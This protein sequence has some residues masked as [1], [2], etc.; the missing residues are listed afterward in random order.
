VKRLDTAEVRKPLIS[1]IISMMVSPAK[2]LK[3]SVAKVP[4]YFSIAVSASAF[5]LFFFQTGFDLYRTGQKG[6]G[7]AL[8]SAG[9]GVVYGLVVIP[10]L[11]VILWIILKA[12]KTEKDIGWAISSFCLSYSGA[13]IYGILGI[14][15][16][17][18]FEWRTAIAFGVTGVLWATGPIIA[19]IREMTN[20]KSVLGIVLAT[21]VGVVVL[22]TWSLFAAL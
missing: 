13:L 8:L 18:A 10:L 12:L 3:S 14:L 17:I 15:F 6:F 9:T 11:G 20:D 1:T 4:W 16:S 21:L 5:G 7:F 2:A 22:F 19:T